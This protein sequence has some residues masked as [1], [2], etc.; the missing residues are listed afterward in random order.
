[1]RLHPT[2]APVHDLAGIRSTLMLQCRCMCT[3]A[4]R[5]AVEKLLSSLVVSE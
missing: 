4:E 1:M 5:L 3:V 2:E